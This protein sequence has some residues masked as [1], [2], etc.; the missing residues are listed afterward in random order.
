MDGRVCRFVRIEIAKRHSLGQVDRNRRHRIDGGR[1]R[2]DLLLQIGYVA[3]HALF[4]RTGS[5]AQGI[6]I[7]LRLGVDRIDMSL[8]LGQ[9]VVAQDR[10]PRA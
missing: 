8:S 10:S 3:L 7:V 4:C 6:A 1:R 2:I 5:G 9:P